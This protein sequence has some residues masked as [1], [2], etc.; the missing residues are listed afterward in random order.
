MWTVVDIQIAQVPMY[1]TWSAGLLLGVVTM[2]GCT[3]IIM[4]S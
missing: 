3:E 4:G 2:I 1:M